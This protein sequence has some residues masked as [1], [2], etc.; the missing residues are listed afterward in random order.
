MKVKLLISDKEVF[1]VQVNFCLLHILEKTV[2]QDFP[3][4]LFDSLYQ[5]IAILM[6]AL[7]FPK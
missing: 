7:F 1:P 4:V 3:K 6:T 5:Q 2:K